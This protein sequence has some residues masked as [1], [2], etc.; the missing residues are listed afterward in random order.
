MQTKD[1]YCFNTSSM[2]LRIKIN[3][4]IHTPKYNII[5]SLYRSQSQKISLQKNKIYQQK[6]SVANLYP[7]HPSLCYIKFQEKVL[8]KFN[9]IFKL[10]VFPY[11]LQVKTRFQTYVV[12]RITHTCTCNQNAKVNQT[13]KKINMSNKYLIYVVSICTLQNRKNQNNISVMQPLCCKKAK[14]KFILN[15]LVFAHILEWNQLLTQKSK[16]LTNPTYFTS[17][18]IIQASWVLYSQTAHVLIENFMCYVLLFVKRQFHLSFHLNE[19]TKRKT[20]YKQQRQQVY[21][22]EVQLLWLGRHIVFYNIDFFYKLLLNLPDK[23]QICAKISSL[24]KTSINN[25]TPK[26]I[27]LIQKNQYHTTEVWFICFCIC[28]CIEENFRELLHIFCQ[29]YLFMLASNQAPALH[30]YKYLS[31]M[32]QLYKLKQNRKINQLYQKMQQ[33]RQYLHC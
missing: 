25:F 1:T 5:T 32:S 13:N 18:S 3:K 24:S 2:K 8:I 9:I 26:P 23:K 27:Q 31:I 30:M 29:C 14:K 22:K 16:Y 15:Y 21:R 28:F 19:I 33:A 7:N 4:Q 20:T 12:Q 6:S 11:H 17:T 10:R